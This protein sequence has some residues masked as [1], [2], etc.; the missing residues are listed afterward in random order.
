MDWLVLN[1]AAPATG[2]MRWYLTEKRGQGVRRGDFMWNV[3]NRI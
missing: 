1:L 2:R 3:F